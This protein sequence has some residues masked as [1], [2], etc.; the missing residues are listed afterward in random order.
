[1]KRFLLILLAASLLLSGCTAGSLVRAAKEVTQDLADA[2]FSEEAV[3]PAPAAEAEPTASP[4]PLYPSGEGKVCISEVM[5]KNKATLRDSS[6]AFPDWIELENLTDEDLDL[7]GWSLAKEDG[8]SSALDGLTL[9]ARARLVLFADKQPE[10]TAGAEVHLSFALS[11]GNTLSLLDRNGDAVSVCRI[12]EEKSDY[13]LVPD[14]SG[15][16]SLSAMPTPGYE[17]SVSGWEQFQET[18]VPAGPLVINEVCVENFSLY[19]NEKLDEY[20]DWVEIKNI[21]DETVDLSGFCLSDDASEPG[22]GT[23]SGWLSPG[24]TMIFLCDKSITRENT[25]LPFVLFSL[26]SENEQLYLSTA[27]GEMVDHISLKEIPYG[28][29]YGRLTGR[30]GYFYLSEPS[31]TS[32]NPDGWRRVAAKPEAKEPDG[33]F[34]DVSSVTVE[35]TGEGEIYYTLDCSYPTE[36]SL[37]YTGPIVLTETTVVRAISVESGA[38]TN[39]PLTLSY[40]INENHTLPVASLVADDQNR[41]TLT[42]N[43]GNKFR[44]LAGS[45]SFY[46]DS[47]SFTAGCGIRLYGESSLVLPKKNMSLRF[48]GCYGTAELDYD[49]FGGG[50]ESFT[51]LVLRAGQDQ[52][53]TIIRNELCYTLASEFSDNVIVPRYRYIILYLN[54]SYNGI[55]TIMEKPNEQLYASIAGVKKSSVELL[56]ATVYPATDLYQDVFQFIYAN[57]MSHP[58]NFAHVEEYLDID[59]LIDWT[60]LQG[61]L[62]NYDLAE[63]NLRYVRSAEADGLWHLVFYDLDCAFSQPNHCFY[64]VFSYG[65]QISYINTL[66]TRSDEYRARLFSRAAEAFDTVLNEEHLLETIDALAA[67]V[68]PEVERDSTVSYM[69][70]D[71]WEGHLED[72]RTFITGNHWDKLTIEALCS[73]ANATAEERELYFGERL[74]ELG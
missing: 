60:I 7:T 36:E 53:N 4:A 10:K 34:N 39:A 12:T 50:V 33:V 63:G 68:E 59:S 3:S 11:S 29:T 57:S 65:N 26:D 73:N 40:I 47:G 67:L 61:W 20:P 72:L 74:K 43:N 15:I 69:K 18:L 41:F 6:G 70:K 58:E 56:E 54:G 28:L 52:Y 13:S 35:L 5:S 49:L 44:E 66:L 8:A 23:L 2:A 38:A 55:Y 9:P 31:P 32:N 24:E 1:M 64:N 27:D 25:T 22:K 48:R 46:E 17:N 45:I 42:Y 71:V 21:S 19:Y 30:N 51:N 37:R 14:S 62:G 16:W